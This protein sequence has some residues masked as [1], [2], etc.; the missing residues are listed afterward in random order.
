MLRKNAKVELIKRCASSSP[1]LL[2]GEL[3]EVAG[4]GTRSRCRRESTLTREGAAR[5]MRFLVLA[6]GYRGRSG[7]RERS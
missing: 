5:A 3:E 4:I 2:E 1:R 6:D 7:G